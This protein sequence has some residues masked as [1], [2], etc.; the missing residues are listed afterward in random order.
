M[1]RRPPCARGFTL[2]EVLVAL[3][4]AAVAL[5]AAL[6]AT[7]S[8]AN[9]ND[10]L[11]LRTLALWSAEN[12]LVQY[13]IAGDLPPVGRNTFDCSQADVKLSCQEDIYAT[14]SPLM[15]RIEVA[16][17]SVGSN[18]RQLAKLTGFASSN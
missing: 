18:P 13:R 17:S 16:V 12:R 3:T 8:L 10:E 2:I 6:R 15:R 7:G 4:I 14:N 1:S 11:R 9:T 5:M